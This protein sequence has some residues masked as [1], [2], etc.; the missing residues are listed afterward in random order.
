MSQRRRRFANKA[1]FRRRYV[2]PHFRHCFRSRSLAQQRKT[3]ATATAPPTP[4]A[5]FLGV[6]KLPPPDLLGQY[7][8]YPAPA[9]NRTHPR[10]GTAALPRLAR[11]ACAGGHPTARPNR[12]TSARPSRDG[13]KGLLGG[14][15]AETT[16]VLVGAGGNPARICARSP[17][18]PGRLAG[19]GA[20]PRSVAPHCRTAD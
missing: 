19:L 20:R 4:D 18:A 11:R 2:L 15:L 7:R 1:C 8:G 12:R 14:Y 10:R 5:N 6:R 9:P 3:S 17:G 16:A 13:R